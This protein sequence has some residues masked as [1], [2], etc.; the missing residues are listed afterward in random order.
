[1]TIDRLEDSGKY[2]K[3][4]VS[5]HAGDF[6]AKNNPR[7]WRF[8]IEQSIQTDRLTQLRPWGSRRREP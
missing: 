3:V 1:M 6:S 8:F 7:V 4:Y 5:A 2:Y